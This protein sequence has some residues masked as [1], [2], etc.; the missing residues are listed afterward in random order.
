MHQ[1]W[2]LLWILKPKDVYRKTYYVVHMILINLLNIL[3]MNLHAYIRR[4]K[5]KK[6]NNKKKLGEGNIIT[7]LPPLERIIKMKMIKSFFKIIWQW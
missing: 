7:E 4:K 5:L 6:K 3:T 2:E 1:A